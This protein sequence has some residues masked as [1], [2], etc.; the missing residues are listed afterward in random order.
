[1][2]LAAL[3]LAGWAAGAAAAAAQPA[4]VL[5]VPF[6]LE[7]FDA[8]VGWLGEG[9][10]VGVTADLAAR[11]VDAVGRDER[12]AAFERLQLPLSGALTRATIIK[13]AEIVGAAQ[14]V[15][16]TVDEHEGTVT[17]EPRILDVDRGAIADGKAVSGPATA[18]LDLFRRL[19]DD[20]DTR[21]PGSRPPAGTD[22]PPPA[23]E[24]YVRGLVASTPEAQ[25]RLLTQAL[26]LAPAYLAAREALWD[27]QTE[28]GA[29]ES[30]LRTATAVKSEPGAP[31]IGWHVR[32]AASLVGLKRYDEAFTRLAALAGQTRAPVV[33]ALQGVI[34]LRRGATPQT[35]R[36]TYFF[37]QAAERDPADGDACFNL[38]YAYWLDKDPM[39]AAYW[40]R[41]AVRR[42]PA[43]G[44]AHFVL[45]A[46]LTA[47]GAGPEAERERELARRLSA[48]WEAA[49]AAEAVPRGL[50]R[51]PE[52]T[53]R[54][55]S[56]LAAALSTGVQRD[57]RDAAAFQ[58]EAAR[59]AF[60]AGRDQEA[61]R[62]VQRALYSTPYDADALL[63]LGRAQA[64]SGL[65]QEAIDTFKIAIWSAETATAQVELGEALLRARDPA[66]ALRAAERALMLEPANAA[67]ADLARRAG[68]SGPG[69]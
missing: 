64:R 67:A 34:Q 17:I 36:A 13:V 40:L 53:R 49:P 43:D 15:V 63:L 9:V 8:R 16:G 4:R 25:E 69:A 31:A 3:A 66:A 1:M 54:A 21:G 12:L 51:L 50:E 2:R 39:A 24:L 28:R 33:P 48:R 58:L 56:H 30:A 61:I 62:A 19:G 11:G 27:A 44:D 45:A 52:M 5:V 38:G 60:E 47:S 7:R 22:P 46:A 42:D 29:H 10:A 6:G 65:I 55:P 68:K 57:Q 32:A 23:F 35:G 41:E 37:S 59:R 26:D 18:L 14:V 20:I